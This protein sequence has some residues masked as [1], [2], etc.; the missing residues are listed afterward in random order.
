MRIGYTNACG[1]LG[2]QERE[3]ETETETERYK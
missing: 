3:T 2:K 1:I